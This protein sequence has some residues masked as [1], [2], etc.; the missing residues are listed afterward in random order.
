MSNINESVEEHLQSIV[1]KA[2][3]HADTAINHPNA[4]AGQIQGYHKGVELA[5]QM[6]FG[7]LGQKNMG[8]VG[9]HVGNLVGHAKDNPVASAAV[10]GGGGALL[11]SRYLDRKKYY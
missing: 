3:K 11:A 9:Q 6:N 7:E 4:F 10:A 8:T 5:K 2:V 1:G